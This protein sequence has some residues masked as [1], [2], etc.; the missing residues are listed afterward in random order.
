VLLGGHADPGVGNGHLD[1][2]ATVADP[3]RSE[4]DLTLLGEL[5]G[6]A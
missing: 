1:P 2:V 3:P 5:T 6:I 4:L